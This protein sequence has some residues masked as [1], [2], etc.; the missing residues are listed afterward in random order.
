MASCSGRGQNSTSISAAPQ[1]SL[2][3]RLVLSKPPVGKVF[4]LGKGTKELGL[5]WTLHRKTFYWDRSLCHCGLID[6]ASI[7]CEA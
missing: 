7:E 1:Q 5:A 3:L 2:F 6:P 4:I